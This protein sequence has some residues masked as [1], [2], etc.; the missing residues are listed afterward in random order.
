M[1]FPD[2]R[3][4]VVEALDHPDPDRRRDA[5]ELL[6]RAYRQPVL[7]MLRARW[8]LQAAD[9]DD[10]TQEFFARALEKGWLGR[11]NPAKGR[12]RTFLRVCAGRFAANTHQAAGRQK[13][14]GGRAELSV[15]ELAGLLPDGD[16][17]AERRFREAWVRS[18]FDLA[19]AEFRDEALARD[20]PVHLAL[21]EGYDLTD[22][23]DE[24]RPTYR[25]LAATH[26]IGETQVLNHLA[27][28]RRR[29][30]AHVLSVLRRLAGSD[31][32]YREDVRELLG[33]EAP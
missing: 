10:L 29:F 5:A 22:A 12:F 13:R 18:V 9:A 1:P 6:V 8:D 32:E 21:F 27:W 17:D 7:A 11:Y 24:E 23:P 14:G 25:D 28:S 3:V 19:L 15:E 26:G 30:R 20:R 31:A 2:T 16:G 33:I 4:S